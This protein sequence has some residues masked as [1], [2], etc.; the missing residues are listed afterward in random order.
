MIE[1]LKYLN[2]PG[3]SDHVALEFNYILASNAPTKTEQYCEMIKE[4]TR[5]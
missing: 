5:E 1:Q 2:P 4:S 3:G